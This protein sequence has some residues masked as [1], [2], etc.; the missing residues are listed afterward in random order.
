MTPDPEA[1]YQT[2]RE[3]ADD[4]I[5]FRA[6][7][8]VRAVAEDLD[9][10]RRTFTPSREVGSDA[11]R[12][13]PAIAAKTR[14]YAREHP[15][16][17]NPPQAGELAAEDAAEGA[18]APA[19]G[20]AATSRAA[21]AVLLLAGCAVGSVA[22]V[23]ELSALST[24]PAARARDPD[25]N[26]HRPERD[27][28]AMDGTFQGQS[29]VL[30]VTRPAEA[31]EGEARAGGG[32]GDRQL[33]EQ[34]RRYESGWKAAREDLSRALVDRPGRHRARQAPP[35]RR[36][37]G[38]DQRHQ[39]SQRHGAE[40]RRRTSS[41]KRSA[42]CRI[43]PIRRSAWRA[44]TSTDCTISIAPTRR[45]SRP[46]STGIRWAI[47]RRRSSPTA[48]AIAPIASFGIRATCAAC[49]R[50]RTRSARRSRITS[51]RS[52]C[53]RSIAPYGNSTVGHSGCAD[54]SGERQF[55]AERDR[56]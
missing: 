4:L 7:G 32:P 38:A 44:S 33:S 15:I 11:T 10:T 54:Q 46:R 49:R 40:R 12:R 50:R 1:R 41:M 29:F 9:A 45:C 55:P 16:A 27:L 37:P 5:M 22:S 53:I 36:P 13:T 30:T 24:R 39:P 56:A 31:G 2:A 25:R 35:G 18:Q 21:S 17:A 14:R 43:R 8:P 23:S 51:G 20:G 42:C 6:G 34:R 47:A 19:S 48:I 3:F 28:G 52:S 26:A